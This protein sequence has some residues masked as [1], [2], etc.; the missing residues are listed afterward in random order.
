[1]AFRFIVMDFYALYGGLRK[2]K[3]PDVMMHA[4]FL[5]PSCDSLCFER[6]SWF[7]WKHVLL[8]DRGTETRHLDISRGSPQ[9]SEA[10]SGILPKISSRSLPS[11]FLR[12]HYL[13]YPLFMNHP[14]I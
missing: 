11:T 4:V 10:D 13:R 7:E 8:M 1:M 12:V 2:E 9:P 5:K 3:L 6:F 14:N